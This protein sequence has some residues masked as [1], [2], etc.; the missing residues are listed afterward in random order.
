MYIACLVSPPPLFFLVEELGWWV[1]VEA[2]TANNKSVNMLLYCDC[3]LSVKSVIVT[4]VAIRE[5]D[6]GKVLYF[7]VQTF[8]FKFSYTLVCS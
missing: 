2:L 4:F 5:E 6:V 7:S 3:E 8:F 1:R